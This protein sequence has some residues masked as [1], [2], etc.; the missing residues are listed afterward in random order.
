MKAEQRERLFQLLLAPLL[1]RSLR[2]RR[3]ALNG[4]TYTS[5]NFIV[6]SF[7]MQSWC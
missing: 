1:D 5:P 2:E 4:G 7:A 3:G 6:P